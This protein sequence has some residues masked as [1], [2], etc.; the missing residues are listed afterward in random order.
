MR[1]HN[2]FYVI[3]EIIEADER[4]LSFEVRIFA[5]M[6]TS[7]TWRGMSTRDL[8]IFEQVFTSSLL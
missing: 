4:K 7:V 2:R 1:P 5:Q 8:V 6:A 3:H